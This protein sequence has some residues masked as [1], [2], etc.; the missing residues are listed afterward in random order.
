[1]ALSSSPAASRR[2]LRNSA[3]CGK[4]FSIFRKI[5]SCSNSVRFRTIVCASTVC[6]QCSVF[7]PGSFGLAG[8][9]WKQF[10]KY[11]EKGIIS[12]SSIWSWFPTS[13]ARAFSWGQYSMRK[14]FS[15]SGSSMSREAVQCRR[16]S[17][18]APGSNSAVALVISI[19]S[20]K[21]MSW[22]SSSRFA[23]SAAVIFL[24]VIFLAF[25]LG[26]ALMRYL[27]G[28]KSLGVS[29]DFFSSTALAA[30]MTFC[31]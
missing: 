14:S 28:V 10:T 18:H 2:C 31:S 27:A 23:R 21:L 15:K 4:A 25:S 29:V 3:M 11:R 7:C 17:S 26:M 20:L 5:R 24:T 9:P 12:G 13:R 8:V 6:S 19:G 22:P 30:S 16:T 1:M